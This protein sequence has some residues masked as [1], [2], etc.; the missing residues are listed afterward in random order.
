MDNKL[1]INESFFGTITSAD[2]NAAAAEAQGADNSKYVADWMPGT[3]EES[4]AKGTQAAPGMEL[5]FA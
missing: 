2:N 1:Y 3:T 4:P 5:W